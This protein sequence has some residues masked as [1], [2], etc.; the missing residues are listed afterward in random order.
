[1]LVTKFSGERVRSERLREQMNR[2]EQGAESV[3]L[4]CL[5]LTFTNSYSSHSL[6]AQLFMQ[7]RRH[8]RDGHA[9]LKFMMDAW[10][11]HTTMTSILSYTVA[12]LSYVS[13]EW[14]DL[15]MTSVDSRSWKFGNLV[16]NRER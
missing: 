10:P 2:V 5:A 9:W 13:A 6:H 8:I 1:M 7:Q 4:T 3:L 15:L 11:V 14:R 12:L 16:R